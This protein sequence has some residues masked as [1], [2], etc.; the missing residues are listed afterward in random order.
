MDD[1]GDGA[2][3]RPIDPRY[4]IEIDTEPPAVKV[5]HRIYTHISPDGD[6]RN[7]S[8]SVRYRLT[9]RGHGILIVDGHQEVRTRFARS[10]PT[11]QSSRSLRTALALPASPEL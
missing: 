8:F 6:R 7:D 10:E 9:E 3:L 2:N 1:G 11:E 5:R 4:R